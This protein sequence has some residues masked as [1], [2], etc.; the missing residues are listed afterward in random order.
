M[1]AQ[2]D[3]DE[4]LQRPRPSDGHLHQGDDY[5]SFLPLDLRGC[6]LEI[7]SAIVCVLFEGLD[8]CVGWLVAIG[9]A[10][11]EVEENKEA[12]EERNRLKGDALEV[13]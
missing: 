8:F 13:D 9:W 2:C 12:R 11:G 7:L 1:S 6:S 3:H 5:G 10:N 4:A